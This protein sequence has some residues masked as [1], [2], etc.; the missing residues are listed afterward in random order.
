MLSFSLAAKSKLWCLS[1]W[2]A[3]ELHEESGRE[4]MPDKCS[5]HRMKIRRGRGHPLRASKTSP[6]R[7]LINYRGGHKVTGLNITPHGMNWR[8]GPPGLCRGVQDKAHNLHPIARR[9]PPPKPRDALRNKWL[10]SSS[11]VSQLGLRGCSRLQDARDWTGSWTGAGRGCAGDSC[12]KGGTET[13]ARFNNGLH[14]T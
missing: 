3:T 8:S 1:K 5:N 14:I 2:P 9:H 11:Q 10:H 13:L 4:S 12:L 6:Q 7:L